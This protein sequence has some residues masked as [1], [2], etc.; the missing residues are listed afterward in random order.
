MTCGWKCP[1]SRRRRG[2]PLLGQLPGLGDVGQ[3]V[4]GVAGAGGTVQTGHVDRR[5]GAGLLVLLPRLERVVHRLDPAVRRAADDHVAQPQRA[6]SH[7]QL[8]HDAALFVHFGFEAGAAGGAIGVGLVFAQLGHRQQR[9]Q[10]RV[11]AFARRG[12]GLDHFGIAAPLA[13]QQAGGPQLLIGP[14][15]VGPGQVDLVQRHHD[16]HVGRP[17]VA[18]RLFGLRHHSV[19]GR[20]DQNG[21]V[22]D[23]GA[24]ARISVNASW[25]G[26][27]TKAIARPSFSTR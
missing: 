6:G 9:F 10:Q 25:P 14:F 18:D 17:G 12:A 22:G 3:H 11:D 20:D 24:A 16:R 8:R 7:Q 26:V 27:S 4:E 1:S 15:N 19:L 2:G 13:R 5:R 23:V 21:D